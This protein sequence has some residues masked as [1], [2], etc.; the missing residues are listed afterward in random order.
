M[1]TIR[2]AA[3]LRGD[4]VREEVKNPHPHRSYSLNGS[5]GAYTG[6]GSQRMS[7]C[8]TVGS[9]LVECTPRESALTLGLCWSGG[10]DH[11]YRKCRRPLGD[12]GDCDEC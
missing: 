11:R 7:E 10:E 8:Y 12:G 9:L 4:G 5:S 3:E 2:T 1:G 6:D